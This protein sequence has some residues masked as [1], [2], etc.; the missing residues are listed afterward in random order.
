METNAYLRIVRQG[1]SFDL[2]K[3]AVRR[4]SLC[5]NLVPI[6]EQGAYSAL[7]DGL[8]AIIAEPSVAV[9]QS[10][11]VAMPIVSGDVS[12][13]RFAV[14]VADSGDM[15]VALAADQID[16]FPDPAPPNVVVSLDGLRAAFQT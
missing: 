11:G 13:P 3:E 14:I 9:S 7:V 2:P 5:A 16:A 15:P 10:F 1:R 12:A 8:P 6:G 4:V